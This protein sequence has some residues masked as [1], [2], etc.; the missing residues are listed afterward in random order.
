MSSETRRRFTN[1]RKWNTGSRALALG[2]SAAASVAIL[3][4][5][6][7]PTLGASQLGEAY[8]LGPADQ[9]GYAPQLAVHADGRS[10]A[11]WQS[12][13]NNRSDLWYDQ[14]SPWIGWS[15][16][17]LLE[18]S[19]LGSAH[20]ARVAIDTG[21]YAAVIWI[22][23]DGSQYTPF[24]AR[25]PLGGAWS[26]PMPLSATGVG[27]AT[28]ADIVAAADGS[29]MAVWSQSTSLGVEMFASRHVPASG[30]G[31]AELI[32]AS[33]PV[34]GSP[35][36]AADGNS[37][38]TVVWDRPNGTGSIVVAARFNLTAGWHAPVDVQSTTALAS[39]PQIAS[40]RGGNVSLVWMPVVS[41][42]GR[43]EVWTA[44]FSD[45]GGWASP[46]ALQTNVWGGGGL[47]LAVTTDGMFIAA[48]E[49]QGG[50]GS[51][52]WTSATNASGAWSSA[53]QFESLPGGGIEPAIGIG[54]GGN[55]TIAWIQHNAS[56]FH[57]WARVFV[58]GLGW[59][60]PALLKAGGAYYSTGL[61]VGEDDRG[62][63]TAVWAQMSNTT[64][65]IWT[66]RFSLRHVDFGFDSSPA[67]AVVEVEGVSSATPFAFHCLET[68]GY[69]VNV[70][71]P[72]RNNDTRFLFVN[73][74]NSTLNDGTF[75]CEANATAAAMF[76][77][78]N[79]V[80]VDSLPS[81][82]SLGLQ[83]ENLSTPAFSWVSAGSA[84]E[85]S[86]PPTQEAYPVRWAFAAWS[87]GGAPV[88]WVNV[89]APT[90][91]IAAYEAAEY[92]VAVNASFA[93][94]AVV[95]DGASV[96][97]PQ[98]V[99]A[100]AN[101]THSLSVPTPQYVAADRRFVFAGWS[102]GSPVNRF[103]VVDRP[104]AIEA[105]FVEEDLILLSTSPSGLRVSWDGV[106][107]A[108][109][110]GRWGENNTVHLL[111]VPPG[112]QFDTAEVVTYGFAH[113]SDGK[114][115]SH[116]AAIEGPGA[117]SAQFVEASF[118]VTLSTDPP[119][120]QVSVNGTPMVG[121]ALFF[122]PAHTSIQVT[123][124]PYQIVGRLRY[125]F[126][127]WR[128]GGLANLTIS[129][130]VPVSRLAAF[131]Y[132]I[133]VWLNASSPAASLVVDARTVQAPYSA[134]WTP[135]S[136]HS[137]GV[138]SKQ[139]A[140]QGARIVWLAW[141]DGGARE[142]QV[143]VV[144]PV[145][146]TASFG[147]EYELVVSSEYDGVACDAAGCWYADG[148]MAALQVQTP[149]PIS[150][151]V[152]AVFKGWGGAA[153]GN[154]TPATIEVSSAETVTALWRLEY[155][156]T[157]ES[158]YGETIGGGWYP[159]GANASP[160]VFPG[161]VTSAGV[162]YRFVG[163]SLPGAVPTTVST[164][165]M[166]A[167]LHLVATWQESPSTFASDSSSQWWLVGPAVVAVGSVGALWLW[168]RK[169]AG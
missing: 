67:G 19:D 137:V 26:G 60:G 136:I 138:T 166:D 13:T 167:P 3:A 143:T 64:V 85:V 42:G 43:T 134:W 146:I 110:T 165:R 89:T 75:E 82:L 163:W 142:H 169:A 91:L 164:V 73:W 7:L 53:T 22:Q 51:S 126:S 98:I 69:S 144:D 38:V 58:E 50:Q 70:T 116:A 157:L 104:M 63:A 61:A 84:I 159:A 46:H 147:T 115:R 100:G 2:L 103:D 112:E 133:G 39:K 129:V 158:A 12:W 18:T 71:T 68:F 88:H 149:L 123:I 25:M 76:S 41:G 15:G 32:G 79:L 118:L 16:P 93:G 52:I 121:P 20:G 87:D 107:S 21:G 113:W 34:Y 109:P 152:R 101:S 54:E 128:E 119:G 83:G 151:G 55:A 9:A 90:R 131:S 57:V 56:I 124:E 23:W 161:E 92:A 31:S 127:H 135:G 14:Y 122:W 95:F 62:N 28:A 145:V 160:S 80:V 10:V 36:C 49:E 78:E 45:Q 114:P 11:V 30:W 35:R 99:W 5:L 74:S 77:V 6:A 8:R 97:T 59:G 139:A 96:S 102:D 125:A 108:T 66:N 24:A 120:L 4:L 111:D 37:N 17:Q 156:L 141:S 27:N 105:E 168:K 72:Q 94:L 106:L 150:Q 140:G 148:A 44:E 155:L 86:A 33:G 48:W 130:D 1:S 153:S 132:E 81:G 65:G 162:S 29:L 47:A 154:A 40:D 117:W